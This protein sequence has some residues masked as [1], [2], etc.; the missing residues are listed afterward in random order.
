M[1]DFRLGRLKFNWRGAWSSSTAYVIDDIISFKGNTYVCVVNHTS[2]ASETSWALTD[3]DIATPRWQLHVPGV[4]IMGA[5]TPNTFYAKND[6]VSYGANQYLC[7]I[8]HT[9]AASETNFYSNDLNKW[10]LYVASTRYLGFWTANT[11]YKLNDIV[12]YGNTLYLTT[13]AHTSSGSTIDETKFSVFLE[14]LE[15]ENT[16]QGFVPAGPGGNPPAKQATQYQKGDIVTYGGYVYIASRI[17]TD[18]QPNLYPDDWELVTTGFEVKGDYDPTIVYVPGN[19]VQFGGNTYVKVISGPA[20]VSPNVT[21]DWQL[22]TRGLAWK[23]NWAAGTTYQVNDVVKQGSGSYVSLIANNIGNNPSSDDGTKWQSLAQGD[24]VLTLQNPGDILIRNANANVPL[25]IGT[26]GQTLAVSPAGL[27]AWER[28]NWCANVYYVATDGVDDPDYGKNIGKPWKSLRYALSRV[29]NQGTETNLVTIFVKS[30]TYE[31]QLPLITTPYTSIVGDNLRAT[32]IKPKATGLSTD[33]IPVENRFSTMF[34]LSESVTLKDLVLVGME[35]FTPASGSANAMDITQSTIRGVFLRLHPNDPITGKSPYIT[36]CSAFSGRPV[37]AAPNCQGGVG[38]L[39]DKSIYGSTVSNGSMLFDSFTQFHDLGVGF[40]CKDLGNAEIVSSFTYYCHIG[41]TCTG[42][43]R[44]RSLAGNNSYGT[45]GCVSRG[46]DSTE[47]PLTGTVRGQRLNFTYEENSV[48]FKINEQVRQ[49]TVGAAD[50]ALALIIAEPQTNYILIEPITG[51]FQNNKAITGV[52][53]SNV[54]ASG[55]TATTAT[56]GALAGISGKIFTLTDLPVDTQN[57]SAVLPQITGAVKFLNVAGQP[58][59]NDPNY[60]VVKLVTNAGTASVL[61]VNVTR[62]YDVPG[63]AASSVVVTS[64]ARN[65][66]VATI[67]TATGHGLAQGD[68]INIVISNSAQQSFGTP[69]FQRTTV[70]SVGSGTSFTYSNSGGNQNTTALSGGNEASR[71]YKVSSSG[72]SALDFHQGGSSVNLYN[73]STDTILLDNSGATEIDS[74]VT[75]IPVQSSSFTTQIT[76]GPTAFLLI[77]NELM[78]ISGKS[79]SNITVTRGAE[80]TTAATHADGS[81]VYYV[82]KTAAQTTLRGDVQTTFTYLPVFSIANIDNNDII[83]ID[84]EFFRVN[85]Q[86]APTLVGQATI[87]FATPKEVTIPAASN[88]AFEIRLRYSQ[89]RL[90]GHDFLLVGTGGKATTNWPAQPTQSPVQ[91]QEVSEGF[92]GRVYYTSTDQD[93]NFRVGAFFSVEQATGTATLDANAFNLSGLSSLRLGSIGAQLGASINEFST[94]IEL[95]AE[96]SRD[97]AVPTQL[98]AKTY[99][100]NKVGGGIVR[101]SPTFVLATLTSSGTTATATSFTANQ[102]AA[103]DEV[104][105]SGA[106]QAN[107]NGRFI[108]TSVNTSAKSFN[109]TMSGSAASPATPTGTNINVERIQRMTTELQV[110]GDLRLR[111]TWNNASKTFNSLLLEVTDTTSGASSNLI[112]AKVGGSSKFKVDKSGNLTLAGDLTVSGTT[113]TVNSNDLVIADKTIIVANGTS[114]ANNADGA[115]FEVGTTGINLKYN[116]ASTAWKS[117]ADI[118]LATGKS[119]KIN[120]VTV[121]SAT[122]IL[123]LAVGSGGGIVTESATQTLTNKTLGATTFNNEIRVGATPGPG[124]AGQYLISGGANAPATWQTVSLSTSSITNGNSNVSTAASSNVTV[125][126]N[127]TLC[128]TFNTSQNLVVVGTV[129]AQSSIALK[130]NVETISDALSKVMNLRGVEFDYKASGRHQIGVVAEEVEKIV[131][132]VVD[133][134]DGIKSVAYQNL[135]AVII[136]AIKELKS[137]IETL[138]RG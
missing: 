66:N 23:Q 120:G 98:A 138:K 19:V 2:A 37:N 48:A 44:I 95:G 17:S 116:H 87:T 65:N 84:N 123:G 63:T 105:V 101:T 76:P 96:F 45:Y 91:Q 71:V 106:T 113:T 70:L 13:T 14:S 122:S 21:T 109:Y 103:G 61:N 126:T 112:D 7:T 39:I 114:A 86:P 119:I 53:S 34:F 24:S 127:G 41:Y 82:T 38:A 124:S 93:G 88:Q 132:C 99:I 90:T 108:V 133:E 18:K 125:T 40:W 110:D 26:E 42:G 72:G 36:Q 31:E 69:A 111:P 97:T 64:V 78:N 55:A 102:V 73:V 77:N 81:V 137:E 3:L 25:G 35:G 47:T 59:F 11:W 79:G 43:G 129:T 56:S 8:N 30:G 135:V 62:Q 128:A 50:Y 94:D 85:S 131:P 15:F 12:K 130:D 6:L 49:S 4:R 60:Y 134:T 27:P 80:G 118:D 121:L 33:A 58:Q 10:S 5:W 22:V 57:S 117:S 92:P 32:V 75:T 16:W 52:G 107:Y 74:S 83:K 29:A 104:V 67:T 9:A 1:A 51:T 28:N 68:K 136:E 54:V 100:D 115:G 20:G 46:F 89:V